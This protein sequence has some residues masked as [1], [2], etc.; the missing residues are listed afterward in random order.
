MVV[1]YSVYAEAREEKHT[2]HTLSLTSIRLP[3]LSGS[4]PSRHRRRHRLRYSRTVTGPVRRGEVPELEGSVVGRGG[5][6]PVFGY[7]EAR[8]P[9]RV[10]SEDART[11]WLGVKLV[12]LLLVAVAAAAFCG[13]DGERRVRAG[14][15]SQFDVMLCVHVQFV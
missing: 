7:G 12:Q 8:D 10:G 4:P 14:G 11:K 2:T 3:I 5:H 6:D 1:I 15:I 9:I 13:G